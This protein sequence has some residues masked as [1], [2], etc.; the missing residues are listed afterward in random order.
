MSEYNFKRINGIKTFFKLEGTGNP[1]I[2]L[3]GWGT[4]H[5]SLIS[6][7]NFFSSRQQT[8]AVDFPGFGQSGFPESDW[9]VDD[10][11]HWLIAIMDEMQIT[12]ADVLGHSFGGRVAIKLATSFPARVNRLVLIDSAGIRQKVRPSIGRFL[13]KAI[14]PLESIL[15]EK[16][17]KKLR[18]KFYD[19][20]GS[21]DY[22]KSGKLKGTFQK[23][24]TEDLEPLLQNIQQKSLLI[25]GEK[26]KATPLGDAKIMHAQIPNSQLIIIPKTGHYPFLEQKELVVKCLEEFFDEG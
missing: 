8:L 9:S 7:F 3:H 1:I 23:I 10:Y 11:M 18:L 15:S 2:L 14:R 6:L 21:T 24:V 19:L 16:N 5:K 17:Y 12:K 4:S 26:D 20:I 22:L 13:I 25:W